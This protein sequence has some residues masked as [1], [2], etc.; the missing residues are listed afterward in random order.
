MEKIRRTF[1]PISLTLDDAD[2][3]N[4]NTR[5]LLLMCPHAL[6]I[7]VW[8]VALTPF[9]KDGDIDFSV[10]ARL[11]EWYIDNGVAGIF[12]ACQS[13]EIFQLSFGE[14]LQLVQETM[15]IVKGRV[16]VIAAGAIGETPEELIEQCQQIADTG[17]KSVVLLTNQAIAQDANEKTFLE[18]VEKLLSGVPDANFGL[19]ECPYPFKYLLSSSLLRQLA[20][21]GRFNFL[22]ETSC[23]PEMLRSK[24]VAVKGSPLG[25]YMANNPFLLEGLRDGVRGYSGI[26][27]NAFPDH[28]VELCSC[29]DSRPERAEQLQNFIGPASVVLEHLYPASAKSF[30]SDLFKDSHYCRCMDADSFPGYD[31]LALQQLRVLGSASRACPFL[32]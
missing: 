18:L 22:K 11:L 12:A 26:L 4:L 14:R 19:Y 32:V 15:R 8:P 10:Y 13:S 9:N 29:W 31:R 28:L 25:I 1:F 5:F 16:P 2:T 21:T 24:I 7:G 20:D 6:P 30:L 17:V 3:R 27:A 23:D